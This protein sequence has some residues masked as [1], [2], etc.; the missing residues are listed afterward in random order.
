[1]FISLYKLAMWRGTQL[2]F[3][4]FLLFRW[5]GQFSF[6]TQQFLKKKWTPT[7]LIVLA[8]A[9]GLSF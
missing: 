6:H 5:F 4:Y 8:N 3:F 2:L 1:M 9:A 7:S